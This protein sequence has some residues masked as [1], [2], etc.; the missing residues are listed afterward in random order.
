M[1]HSSSSDSDFIWVHDYHLMSVAAELRRLGS[2]AR[3]GFFLH[4]PFPN[5]EL[6]F[7]LP[8]RSWL[9]EGMMGADLVGFHTR[10]YRGHFTAA[11]RRLFGLEMDAQQRVAWRGRSVR[12]S[13]SEYSWAMSWRRRSRE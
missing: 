2:G 12:P 3:I 5:P 8:T 1:V 13:K 9:L 6:F 4:I 7:T 11:L 10:R